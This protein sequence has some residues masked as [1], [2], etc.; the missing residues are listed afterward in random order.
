MACPCKDP[1]TGTSH[2]RQR[3]PRDLVD[4]VKGTRVLLHIGAL[5]GRSRRPGFDADQDIAEAKVR[6]SE[7]DTG[8]E[9]YEDAVRAGQRL[10]THKEAGARADEFDNAATPCI[11]A[12]RSRY[13]PPVV[14]EAKSLGTNRHRALTPLAVPSTTHQYERWPEP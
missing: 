1:K 11:H 2:L 6:L 5:P 4:R 14:A 7:A 9:R 13:L 8:L 10:S 12:D 3:P